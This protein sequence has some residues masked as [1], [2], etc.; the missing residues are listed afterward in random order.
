MS[1][2]NAPPLYAD[3]RGENGTPSLPPFTPAGL[4]LARN[5]SS[6]ETRP[7]LASCLARIT[8]LAPLHSSDLISDSHLAAPCH[9]SNESK[10][11]NGCVTTRARR[12]V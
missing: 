7:L 12:S 8:S 6:M 2:L 11:T 9:M 10:H 3:E 1:G 5:L 4:H